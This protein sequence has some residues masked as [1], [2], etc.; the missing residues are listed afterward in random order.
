MIF[1]Y[2]YICICCNIEHIQTYVYK[3]PAKS[4]YIIHKSSH[5][6]TSVSL[7]L[8]TFSGVGF[9][10]PI[11]TVAKN[12]GAMIEEGH[13]INLGS[14]AILYCN[15]DMT[16]YFNSMYIYAYVKRDNLLQYT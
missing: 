4:I 2:I 9:A 15:I 11:D 13:L 10:L 1:I 12:V 3:I 14:V 7:Q 8:G 5:P 16:Y 6:D